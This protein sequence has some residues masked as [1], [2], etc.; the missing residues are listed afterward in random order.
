MI[1][2]PSPDLASRV[3]DPPLCLPPSRMGRGLPPVPTPLIISGVCLSARFNKTIIA[4]HFRI[5]VNIVSDG[6]S[7]VIFKRFKCTL[8]LQILLECFVKKYDTVFYCA[9]HYLRVVN[10][11]RAV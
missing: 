2:V 10:L 3:H 6:K 1:R 5:T 7:E 11:W 4:K 9:V 8:S